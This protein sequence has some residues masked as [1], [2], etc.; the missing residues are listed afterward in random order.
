MYTVL[1][2]SSVGFTASL[3]DAC[4]VLYWP[5]GVKSRLPSGANVSRL[6][7]EVSVSLK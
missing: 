2:I 4:M 1:V 3:E 7:K 5:A 6:K